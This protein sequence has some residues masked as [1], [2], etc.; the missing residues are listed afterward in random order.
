MYNEQY[1][2]NILESCAWARIG[3]RLE[4]VPFQAYS[5]LPRRGQRMI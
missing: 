5:V 4:E 3:A 2:A 1:E